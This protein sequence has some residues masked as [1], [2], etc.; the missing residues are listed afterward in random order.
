MTNESRYLTTQHHHHKGSII[1]DDRD[2]DTLIWVG[3]QHA[4][5]LDHLRLLLGARCKKPTKEQGI[6][7]ASAAAQ[8]VK[9][10]R[11]LHLIQQ[12]KI[13]ASTPPWIWLTPHGL[14]EL[15]LD[16]KPFSP[17]LGTLSHLHAKLCPHTH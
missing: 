6:L 3:E 4:I 16:F 14:R 5:S 9:R 17:R 1:L 10:W 13:V 12:Q 15:E 8:V 11:M 7:S 2:L